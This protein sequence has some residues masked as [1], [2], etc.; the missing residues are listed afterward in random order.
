MFKI[1]ANPK[2]VKP[3][4]V[5][6][7][8]NLSMQ[9]FKDLIYNENSNMFNTQL[10]YWDKSLYRKTFINLLDEM[11]KLTRLLSSLKN[12]DEN[13]KICYIQPEF[14][15]HQQLRCYVSDCYVVVEVNQ[16]P[17]KSSSK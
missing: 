14:N 10:V 15:E 1:N 3:D 12:F 16:Y 4:F 11:Y 7:K 8:N 13:N 2:L 5:P 9:I 17:T 6:N